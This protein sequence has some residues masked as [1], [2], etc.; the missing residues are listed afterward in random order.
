MTSLFSSRL[1]SSRL[2]Y[3]CLSWILLFGG[4]AQAAEGLAAIRERLESG[5]GPVR[6]VCFGDSVT[7]LYYH[8]GGRRA[9]PELME[10]ILTRLYPGVDVSVINA[11]ISGHTSVNGYARLPQDVLSHRPD[12]VTVMF[13]LNDLAR[14]ELQSYRHHLAEIVKRCRAGGSEVLLCT[15]NAVAETAERPVAELAS[16]A[17]AVRDLAREA[18]VPLCDVHAAF[19]ALQ[20]KDPLAWRLSMS[21]EIHPNFRGHCRL[22]EGLVREILGRP[23][24]P[25]EPVPLSPPLT[26]VVGKWKQGQPVRVLAMPPFDETLPEVLRELAPGM[27]VEMS[28]WPVEGLDR[29]ALT[30]DASHRVRPLAPDLVWIAVPRSAS[31]KDR[32][33]FIRTQMWIANFSL[34]RGSR[35]WDVVVAHPDLF[36]G[37]GS[38]EERERDALVREIVPAQ[39]LPLVDRPA[40]DGREAITLLQDWLREALSRSGADQG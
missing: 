29:S 27:V 6:I 9:Y 32:E 40:G 10:E 25:Q 8:S 33:E 1:V 14:G 18:S 34:S 7:G 28:P 39:D 2:V 21:D 22:A 17:A 12:L 16:F 20:G 15:P 38:E 31:A 36:E 26:K 30:K 24:D 11:G 37:E 35:E 5:R 23:L 4:V 13:G 19:A 3:F